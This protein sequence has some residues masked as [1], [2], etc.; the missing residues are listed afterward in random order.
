M[1]MWNWACTERDSRMDVNVVT[2]SGGSQAGSRP[3]PQSLISHEKS[4]G[5]DALSCGT[6]HEVHSSPSVFP[7]VFLIRD[8]GM[9]HL[10]KYLREWTG[11]T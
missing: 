3:A 7:V 4:G 11:G 5:R 6:H 2:A 1:A 8:V 10:S 9:F